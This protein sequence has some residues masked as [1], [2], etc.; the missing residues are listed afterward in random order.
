[1]SAGIKTAVLVKGERAREMQFADAPAA[2][3]WCMRNR[4]NMV[5]TCQPPAAHQ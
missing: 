2:L 1:M 5:Y 4:A 3:E